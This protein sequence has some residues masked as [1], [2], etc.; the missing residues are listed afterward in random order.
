[1][2]KLTFTLKQHTPIIHFQYEQDGA[3]LRASE[4]KPKLDKYLITNCISQIQ[5]QWYINDASQ[6]LNYKLSFENIEMKTFSI[7]KKTN[8]PCFFGDMGNDYDGNE[9]GL[10]FATDPFK[11]TIRSLHSGLFD[12]I[13]PHLA[14]FFA[15]TNFGTRQSKGFG[16]YSVI[17]LNKSDIIFPHRHYKYRFDVD[18]DNA[19][20]WLDQ[21]WQ[22]FENIDW[23]YRSL[24]S[25][26]NIKKGQDSLYFKSALFMFLYNQQPRIQWDKKTIKAH[27]F[28]RKDLTITEETKKGINTTTIKYIDSQN[29]E[30]GFPDILNSPSFQTNDLLLKDY[31]DLFG[32]SSEE[33]WYS[34]KAD[35]T[36]AQAAF[37]NGRWSKADED[38]TTVTRYQSPILI[39]PILQSNGHYI[40]YFD[41]KT[42]ELE[43]E[44]YGTSFLY[45]LKH[46]D[47]RISSSPSLSTF[48]KSDLVLPIATSF[49]FEDFFHYAFS[50]IDLNSHIKGGETHEELQRIK[51]SLTDIYSQL[52]K[53]L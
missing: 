2:Y 21:N 13:I 31:R 29:K 7:R 45:F 40:V 4:V 35:I 48:N 25:G 27:Y 6:A 18:C 14:D 44:F 30:H 3:T 12:L 8:F 41:A 43:K 20:N 1:M 10:S 50:S 42:G 24:R 37:I 17:E 53:Q 22:L 15:T 47:G 51:E 46:K 28:N 5:K 19:Q 11:G 38:A 34:Y 39:K 36:K 16:S 52:K 33:S 23:F 9:K 32:L 49:N 26:I